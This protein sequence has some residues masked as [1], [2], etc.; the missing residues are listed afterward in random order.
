MTCVSELCHGLSVQQGCGGVYVIKACSGPSAFM[1]ALIIGLITN[2]YEIPLLN[3]SRG[4]AHG[5]YP[6][7]GARRRLCKGKR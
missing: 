6:R 1:E 2:N 4:L 7:L 3:I 5:D